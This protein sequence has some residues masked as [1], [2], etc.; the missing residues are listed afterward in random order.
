MTE[1]EDI[2][3]S[4]AK[5]VAGFMLCYAKLSMREKVDLIVCSVEFAGVF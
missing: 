2:H 3:A 1:N 5:Q 4:Q